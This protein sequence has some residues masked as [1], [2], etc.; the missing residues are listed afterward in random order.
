MLLD[1]PHS[2]EKVSDGYSVIAIFDG[3]GIARFNLITTQ[4][5]EPD[6]QG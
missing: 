5:F 3:R 2:F 6:S 1:T 4:N